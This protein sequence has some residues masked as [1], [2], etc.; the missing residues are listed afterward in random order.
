VRVSTHA[1]PQATVPAEQVK[2]QTP[3][4]HRA[5]P[6]AGAG[7][8][9]LQAPQ[10]CALLVTLT[11][12]PAQARRPAALSRTQSP[13]W[14][15][16]PAAQERPQA[17]QFR[18]SVARA[19]QA[20]LQSAVPTPQRCSQRPAAQPAVPF[21]GGGQVTPQSPQFAGSLATTTQRP[22]QSVKPA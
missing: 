16:S 20:P 7:H 2:P 14:Q 10:C 9:L 21:D 8:A 12:A 15:A 18:G 1:P 5:V 11:Q 19:T 4:A 3:F 13:P 17:P 6:P 22:S